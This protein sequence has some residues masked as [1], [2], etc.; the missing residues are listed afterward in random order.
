M[1]P[2]KSP[3]RQAISLLLA[4]L[5]SSIALVI[6]FNLLIDPYDL[7]KSPTWDGINLRKTRTVNTEV[8]SKLLAVEK[9]KPQWVVLG[10]SREAFGI[11]MTDPAWKEGQRRYN[12][13]FNGASI[14]E[15]E[16]VA[17]YIF[18]APETQHVLLGIDIFMFN[19]F[20]SQNQPGNLRLTS[21]NHMLD[22]K[23]SYKPEVDLL[24]PSI[25]LSIQATKDAWLT[26]QEQSST[27]RYLSSQ[28]EWQGSDMHHPR[29]RYGRIFREIEQQFLP[30]FWM[31]PPY[32]T[33]A[34]RSK[35]SDPLRSFQSILEL[36]HQ[37][38][39]Q[40]VLAIGPMHAR[41][42]ALM[43][44]SGMDQAFRDWQR[45]LVEINENVAA[46]LKKPAFPLFDYSSVQSDSIEAVPNIQARQAMRGFFD[47]NHYRPV[48]GSS[49]L[50]RWLHNQPGTLDEQKLT[51]KTLP[52]AQ[53]H[54]QQKLAQY[55]SQHP[56]DIKELEVLW[57]RFLTA[58]PPPRI[59]RLP[60]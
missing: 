13:A 47:A 52:F 24:L 11:P 18:R 59:E 26:I 50:K 29:Q 9:Q 12:M 23:D 2:V 3:A 41:T 1:A 49:I 55:Q 43:E 15:I 4:L 56:D 57:Q 19:A 54:Q 38:N 44:I 16:S 51:Y 39:I 28:G 58:Q 34:L 14:T 32:N 40:L 20:Y 8:F 17:N 33:F 46:T 42:V 37:N 31:P 21:L 10:N 48:L 45:M 53:Q 35:G 5:T 25:L 22:I 7:I 27:I 60:Q 6:L 36:A 30:H